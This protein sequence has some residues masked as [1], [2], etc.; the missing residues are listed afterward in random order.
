MLDI[1]FKYFNKELRK[2]LDKKSSTEKS[3]Y[4][5]YV[6][7]TVWSGGQSIRYIL[8]WCNDFP[9]PYSMQQY[10]FSKDKT[11]LDILIKLFNE[12]ND[13]GVSI[14]E[15]GYITGDSMALTKFKIKYLLVD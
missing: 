12:G 2:I 13:I 1:K 8:G 7:K 9:S 6:E 15:H 4:N 14:N 5:E 3:F 11:I 10:D